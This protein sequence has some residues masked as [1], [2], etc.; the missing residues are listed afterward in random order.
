MAFSLLGTR[1]NDAEKYAVI[2]PN[3]EN[4]DR[5]IPVRSRAEPSVK[6]VQGMKYVPSYATDIRK[7]LK[8]AAR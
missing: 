6:I 4:K 2:E 8:K 5:Q 7:T 3:S 1:Y